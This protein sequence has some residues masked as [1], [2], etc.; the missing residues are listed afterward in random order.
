MKWYHHWAFELEKSVGSDTLIH[1]NVGLAIWMIAALILR[2]PFRNPWLLLPVVIA[3]GANEICD[4]IVH[5]G[6]SVADTLHDILWTLLWPVLLFAAS[7][8][9]SRRDEPG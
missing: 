9:I 4:Y 6:W 1:L 7:F 2:Q 5:E 8:T 3:E